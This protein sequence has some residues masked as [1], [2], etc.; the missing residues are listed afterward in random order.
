MEVAGGDLRVRAVGHS[1]GPH[2]PEAI[3]READ[4]VQPVGETIDAPWRPVP[5]VLG[6][7]LRLVALA[8]AD[9][10]A[11]AARRPAEVLD[12][13]RP[14]QQAERLAAVG[15]EHVQLRAWFVTVAHEGE[16]AA[17]RRPPWPA[18]AVVAERERA[19]RR[20][21]VRGCDPDPAAVAVL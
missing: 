13:L 2:V 6:R 11:I 17:V 15:R 1:D 21:P 4:A 19:R 18:V 14:R 9:R 8:C 7:V 16:P 20:R 10:E 5:I 12:L 3:R